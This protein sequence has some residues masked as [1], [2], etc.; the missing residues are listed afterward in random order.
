MATIIPE[1]DAIRNAVKWVSENRQKEPDTPVRKW[2]EQAGM[3][4]NLSPKEQ[5]YLYRFC[6]EEC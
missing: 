3:R 4:F 2:V 1:G 6:R 5:E